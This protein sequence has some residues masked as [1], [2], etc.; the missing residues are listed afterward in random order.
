MPILAVK[1][2][3]DKQENVKYSTIITSAGIVGMSFGSL[4]GGR[5]INNGRRRGALIMCA[6]A[7]I[8]GLLQQFLTIPTLVI[9]RVMQGFAA[10]TLSIVM[11][12]SIVETI[13][14]QE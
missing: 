1:L 4:L 14:T 3:W 12:K 9:G 7:L 6:I 5:F 8:G 13:P 2:D 11:V 10:G